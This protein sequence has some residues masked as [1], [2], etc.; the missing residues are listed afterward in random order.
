MD[1]PVVNGTAYPTLTVDPT[2]YRFQI[3]NA[4]NDRTLNLSWF[5]AEP[6]T[7]AVTIPG[8]GYALPPAA[9]PAVTL[10]GDGWNGCGG[11][12]IGRCSGPHPHGR[13]Q[14]LRSVISAHRHHH[15]RWHGRGGHCYR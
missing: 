4:G 2:A 7:I 14:R 11:C 5:L 13:R 10:T 15:W 8:G 12:L 6:L 3:L 1:T 9:A